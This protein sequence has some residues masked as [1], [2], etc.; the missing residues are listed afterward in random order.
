MTNKTKSRRRCVGTA[1]IEYVYNSREGGVIYTCRVLAGMIRD[2]DFLELKRGHATINENIPCGGL[3]FGPESMSMVPTGSIFALTMDGSYPAQVG[4]LIHG[5]D[6]QT[7]ALIP[8]SGKRS[9][10]GSLRETLS[11]YVCEVI[12]EV[13]AQ[14]ALTQS[15]IAALIGTNQATV[16]AILKGEIPVGY[17]V[18]IRAADAIGVVIDMTL[19]PTVEAVDTLKNKDSGWNTRTS[20]MPVW[21]ELT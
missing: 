10:L 1:V 14:G 8:F 11:T 5:W 13:H 20:L 16:Y 21:H 6:S 17:D 2:S 19:P 12:K 15:Q 18:I 7:E 9:S 3:N 4:D